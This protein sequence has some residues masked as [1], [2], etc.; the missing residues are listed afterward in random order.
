MN[1]TKY[2]KELENLREKLNEDIVKWIDYR[3]KEEYKDL[4]VK[5]K[6]LDEVIV[7]Y[8]KSFNKQI[9]ISNY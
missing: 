3:N 4:L 7:K 6:E 8:I 2:I 1:N 9:W 5:S